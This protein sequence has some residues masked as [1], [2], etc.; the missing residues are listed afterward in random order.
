MVKKKHH[1]IPVFYLKGF[2]DTA[3]GS[4]LW[5]YNKNGEKIF[6]STPKGIA[7][8]NDY[9]SFIDKS[10]GK[11][12]ES[13]ENWI[14]GVEN[15][16]SRT[17]NKICSRDI[18]TIEEKKSFAIFV[19]MMLLRT[20][21]SRKNI[22]DMY[23]QM[24]KQQSIHLAS[25]RKAFESMIER[26]QQKTGQNISVDIEEL[27]KSIINFDEHFT[28]TVET[29]ASLQMIIP[30]M[31]DLASVFWRM[32]WVFLK[33]KGDHKFL[34]GDNPLSYGTPNLIY[35]VGLGHVDI[36]VTLPLSKEIAAFGSWQLREDC[37]YV[38]ASNQDVK[39]INRNTVIS[40]HRFVFASKKSETLKR[41]VKKYQNT[42]PKISIS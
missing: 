23:A 34:T 24:R 9:F 7:Y 2:T 41:L 36:Q 42:A 25:N 6:A 27:R 16:T 32:K 39:G 35:P 13:F 31:Q 33:T 19:A 17:I 18:L 30:L 12:S 11:D 29:L 37:K 5:V 28:I 14:A 8:E 1:Y 4:C 21:N 3:S 40:A 22:E 20:P 26:Y 10:G 38:Q 15:A